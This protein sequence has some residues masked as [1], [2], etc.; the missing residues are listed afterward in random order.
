MQ[1]VLMKSYR[2]NDPELRLP[3]LSRFLPLVSLPD[4]VLLAQRYPTG[5]IAD[6]THPK[7]RVKVV[8]WFLHRK[9]AGVTLVYI[10]FPCRY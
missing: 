5:H 9:A 10:S 3:G 4:T 2:G 8:S 7:Q 1:K 6:G